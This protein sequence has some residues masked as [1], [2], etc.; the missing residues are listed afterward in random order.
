[1]KNQAGE[2]Q[3]S[4]QN[5]WTLWV[6]LCTFSVFSLGLLIVWL[7]GWQFDREGYTAVQRDWF[8]TLNHLLNAWPAQAWANLTLM[9][10]A[11]VLIPLLS[12]LIL[13][14]AQAWAAI[15]AAAPIASIF[16]VTGKHLAAVPRPAALLDQDQF[17]VIGHV[18][19][20]KNSFPSGHSIT[21]FTGI[22]AVLAIL[23]PRQFS[24]R[25]LLILTAGLFIAVTVGMSRVAVGAHWPLDVLGGMV[26]GMIAGLNGAALAQRYQKWWRL[27][28][29]SL[30]RC[31]VGVL[32]LLL[33]LSLVDRALDKPAVSVV[34]WL[35]A[36]CGMSAAIWLMKSC[37]L[38]FHPSDKRAQHSGPER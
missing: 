22:V 9:G 21:I 15:L 19:S 14:R 33:S 16:S 13:W 20:A 34:L 12:P 6:L 5:C 8:I 4:D 11:S 31:V 18:L 38:R 26:C 3:A 23:Y 27:S 10:D 35:S 17:T 2:I 29:D 7:S 37:L 1:M 28:P 25:Y 36:L 32:L 24:W 30:A